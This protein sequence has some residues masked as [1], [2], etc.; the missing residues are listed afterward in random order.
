MARR[1]TWALDLI[2]LAD[3]YGLTSG[4]LSLGG[5]APLAAMPAAAPLF[6]GG[7]D[8]GNTIA[9]ATAVAAGTTATGTLETG[10]D[11]D[12]FA[13]SVEEGRLY[14]VLS[15]ASLDG[16]GGFLS[17]VDAN[18]IP[19]RGVWTDFL[20]TGEIENTFAADFTGTVYL[21]VT[22]YGD[23][24]LA[25]SV[26]I[27][28]VED[29]FAGDTSTTGAFAPGGGSVSGTLDIP[30][31]TDWFRIELTG[32]N[33]IVLDPS[34]DAAD[35]SRR[36][37]LFDAAGLRVASTDIDQFNNEFYFGDLAEGTYFLEVSDF[38]GIRKGDY[39]LTVST[40]DD[41]FGADRDTAPTVSIF[42][43]ASGRSDYGGDIDT[44]AFT[45]AE[46]RQL[47]FFSD[48][49]TFSVLNSDG[50]TVVDP[51]GLEGFGLLEAGDYFIQVFGASTGQAYT[52][53][54]EDF[55]DD[56]RGDSATTA[57][58][59]VNGANISGTF[60]F[61]TDEDWFQ[62]SLDA[63]R[64]YE[65]SIDPFLLTD[66]SVY[67]VEAD[68]TFVA[69]VEEVSNPELT[70]VYVGFTA[71][72]SGD[73]FLV[74]ALSNPASFG[75]FGPDSYN[76]GITAQELAEDDYAAD[77]TTTGVVDFA[78]GGVT[79]SIERSGDADWFAFDAEAGQTLFAVGDFDIGLRIFDANG[80]EV[81][82]GVSGA[83]DAV[84]FT[85]LLFDVGETG[86]Y[87]LQVEDN[88]TGRAF[89]YQVAVSFERNDE[90][91]AI[92]VG[93]VVDVF[94]SDGFDEDEYPIEL[95]AGVSY[96]YDGPRGNVDA[97]LL[98]PDGN[99]IEFL[100][101]TPVFTVPTS[102][103]Y[104]LNLTDLDSMSRGNRFQM[105]VIEVPED[106][107][108]VGTDAA[109]IG[110]QA[111][112][113]G[114]GRGDEDVFL[115]DPESSESRA[116]LI[117]VTERD[118][119][120]FSGLAS[121][122]IVGEF[123]DSFTVFFHPALSELPSITV[124]LSNFGFYDIAVEAITDD[125]PF[126][127]T[128]A[129]Q[130]G[131]RGT[132]TFDF[133]GDNDVFRLQL[134]APTALRVT[135]EGDTVGSLNVS[136]AA[137]IL[138]QQNFF[139]PDTG[140]EQRVFIVSFD[141]AGAFDLTVSGAVAGGPSAYTVDTQVL[142]DDHGNTVANA[143]VVAIG[144]TVRLEPDYTGDT[145]T[146]SFTAVQGQI[147]LIDR[148]RDADLF[149]D[150]TI[151]LTRPDGTQVDADF[152]GDQEAFLAEQSGTYTVS[153]R[154]RT[155]AE[156]TL[157]TDVDALSDGTDTAG[158]ITANGFARS[159]Y[160]YFGD[161]DAFRISIREGESVV[162][163][164]QTYPGSET[165]AAMTLLDADGNVV[166][167]TFEPGSPLGVTGLAAGDYFVV[168]A[169]EAG[170]FGFGRTDYTLRAV[171][172]IDDFGDG[173]PGTA[174]GSL[175][176]GG[177]AYGVTNRLPD[178]VLDTD[179]FALTLEAGQ[180]VRLSSVLFTNFRMGIGVFDADGVRLA[181]NVNLETG[182][183]GGSL[184]FTAD[185]SGTYTIL[186]GA[187]ELDQL[188]AYTLTAR[189]LVT[190]QAADDLLVGTLGLDVLE[191]GDGSDMLFGEAYTVAP[192]DSFEAQI[193]RAY[194]AVFDRA[195]DAA[196]FDAILTGLRLGIVDQESVITDFVASP[197]FQATY[198]ELSNSEFVLLLY[199]NALG[200]EA[201]A[202]GL[203]AFTNAL[204]AGELTRTEVVITFANSDELIQ[205]S[206]IEAAAFF[207]TVALNPIEGQ[208][209][210]LYQAV[211][212]RE[213]DEAGFT[214]F[215]GALNSGTLTAEQIAAEFVASAEFAAT[216]G[217]LD[218]AAFVELIFANVLPGNEDPVGRAAFLA[219]LDS[220][221]LSRAD[222]VL[223][224]SESP[225]YTAANDA[226]AVEFLQNGFDSRFDVLFGG[227]GDDMLYGGH[228]DDDFVLSQGVDV[229]LD[230]DLGHDRLVAAEF[231]GLINTDELL[232]ERSAQVG[233]DVHIDLGG[234]NVTILANILLEDLMAVDVLV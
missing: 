10:S 48:T 200:R 108:D 27:T 11:V 230:F 144:D 15:S 96:Y 139:D 81:R 100:S 51:G 25:Y 194:Q 89:D 42:S 205:T 163:T 183:I 58:A 209:F 87:F 104:T 105:R 50:L 233:Q 128:A 126:G 232:F 84:T 129:L 122:G 41:D 99:R 192:S 223:A 46:A 179:A 22:A 140:A 182:G 5:I 201:D 29:D 204:D 124:L 78:A 231:F 115:L 37:T 23:P 31:D 185:E 26:Q 161:A 72:R 175:S 7:D 76:F 45:L 167:E 208:V 86:R 142:P 210:R 38:S 70:D 229:I 166:R 191:G 28:E 180:S 93:E 202:E 188:D 65:F 83:S 221:E 220:G 157:S 162:F 136:G 181:T 190:G 127:S 133:T 1:H 103:T 121:S 39:G 165:H 95:Q 110:S 151:T 33:T 57:V 64:T 196:G 49:A 118:G 98:D 187:G 160:E 156:F 225:E 149:Y 216:Y 4:S 102:G 2:G 59:A 9:T 92:A 130:V 228:G 186:V 145:D 172:S 12:V 213:P 34:A 40:V 52:V 125:V 227:A 30:G 219:A 24:N 74:V 53:R 61:D 106:E 17:I 66:M 212:Q 198:G 69:Q 170:G 36:I 206:A 113:F 137:T 75:Q 147:I 35:F 44:F 71:A 62:F 173:A 73:F 21:V 150:A 20:E 158:V 195:P 13:L 171:S 203:A 119:P 153:Y 88:G 134:D 138:D 60:D 131:E 6:M 79:G 55:A 120:V 177:V 80:V 234:G 207:D 85:N 176:L 82:Q 135:L 32:A 211:F 197:E 19:L 222:M 109:L 184:D 154:S 90:T 68:G 164:T 141:A 226:L 214:L 63:G 16:G 146:F 101:S 218:N 174:V 152:F 14:S 199:R 56:V 91:A 193:F 168:V 217:S 77:T 224:L 67:V 189:N 155:A 111:S 54:A 132:G 97:V 8:H 112:G 178:D 47:R 116:F 18:E 215:V 143:T 43:G 114:H 159:S 107:T 123:G 117:T 94:L 3:P 169:S 148:M